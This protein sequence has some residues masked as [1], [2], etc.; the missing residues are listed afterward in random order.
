MKLKR[1]TIIPMFSAMIAVSIYII[2]NIFV[3]II[4]VPITLQLLVI[5]FISY[6]LKPVDTFLSILIYV[7]LGALGLPIFSGFRGGLNVLFGPT[8]GFI[9]LFPIIG[10]M[11]SYFKTK[12]QNKLKDLFIGFIF[13]ILFLYL[14]AN[15]YLSI[16]L[17]INYFTSLFALLIFI[18]FDIIKLVLAYIL[19]LRIPKE[20]FKW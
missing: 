17:G 5:F 16:S 18:P 2:P 7:I 10:F 15:L 12:N 11:I 19:Y 3:P 9:M 14:F 13:G 6:T 4:M 8:G 1:L 20:M